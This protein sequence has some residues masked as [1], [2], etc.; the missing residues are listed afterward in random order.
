VHT[1]KFGK[2]EQLLLDLLAAEKP[3]LI[4]VTGD[5]IT[6][7]KTYSEVGAFLEKLK[8]PLGVLLVRGN[9]EHWRPSPEELDVY[10][11][12]G[13]KFLNNRGIWVR[14]DV[15]VAGIDDL[16]AGK[17]DLAKAMVTAPGGQSLRIGIFHSPEYFDEAFSAFDFIFAGHTHGGQIR[18]PIKG[19][20]FLPPKSGKYVMGWFSRQKSELEKSQMYVSR[21]IGTSVVP[22]RFLCKPELPIIDLVPE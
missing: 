9:W 18:L 19:P 15:W 5:T 2:R 14:D 7:S 11:L 4:L 17:P 3:D 6:D 1:E 20:L 13:V 10:E 16:F 12:S 21:G 8:A 22:A